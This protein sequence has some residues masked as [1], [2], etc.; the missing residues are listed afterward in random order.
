MV[1]KSDFIDAHEFSPVL[2]EMYAVSG[3]EQI[4]S[5]MLSDVKALLDGAIDGLCSIK[6]GSSSESSA[7]TAAN[8]RIGTSPKEPSS[9][10]SLLTPS[11]LDIP[12]QPV[13]SGMT[14][15]YPSP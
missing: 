2:E 3:D 7:S 13:R 10:A 6:L 9:S 1:E 4:V 15:T 8:K 14:H 11:D 5:E 12:L